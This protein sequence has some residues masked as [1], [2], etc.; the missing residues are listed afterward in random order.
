MG[1][2]TKTAKRSLKGAILVAVAVCLCV[3]SDAW[4]ET[5]ETLPAAFITIASDASDNA[6]DA[7]ARHADGMIAAEKYVGARRAPRLARYRSIKLLSFSREVELMKEDVI[8]K[9]Q[10]PGKRR[11]IMMVELKF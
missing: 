3:A 1:T 11:S 6:T 10:S 7:A 4:A 8:V 5:D 2:D 9:V